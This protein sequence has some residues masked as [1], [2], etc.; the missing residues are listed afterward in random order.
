[1]FISL[2]DGFCMFLPLSRHSRADGQARSRRIRL[3]KCSEWNDLDER[4]RDDEAALRPKTASLLQVL[5]SKR[6]GSIFLCRY[7]EMES[8]SKG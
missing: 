6:K 8:V 1:M 7:L 5:R 3:H 2:R 4:L